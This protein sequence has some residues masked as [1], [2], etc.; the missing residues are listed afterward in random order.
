MS[1]MRT[2]PDAAATPPSAT[3]VT[4]KSPWT[5]FLIPS[6]T[7][8][9]SPTGSGALGAAA[10]FLEEIER[11]GSLSI[12]EE[13]E[14]KDDDTACCAPPAVELKACMPLDPTLENIPKTEEAVEAP[15]AA[16]APGG[17]APARTT[18]TSN[19]SEPPREMERRTRDPGGPL[20]RWTSSLVVSAEMSCPSQ[21]RIRSP[22]WMRPEVAA[23]PPGTSFV[24]SKYASEFSVNPIPTPTSP[25][26]A[27]AAGAAAFDRTSPESEL[28]NE[29]GF[30]A[31]PTDA[32]PDPAYDPT[33]ATPDPTALMDDMK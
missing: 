3:W 9:G 13:R 25:T 14:V 21:L 12:R 28:A 16:A 20:M 8:T 10:A 22:I 1:L 17:G 27:A 5:F 19:G 6:P 32:T 15:G 33:E 11:E 4:M 23:A 7:P 24:T 29:E 18:P 26:G 30:S 2:S 31:D